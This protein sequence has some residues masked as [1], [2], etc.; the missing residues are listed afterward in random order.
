MTVHPRPISVLLLALLLGGLLGEEMVLR[1]V[2]AGSPELDELNKPKAQ[3]RVEPV[4]KKADATPAPPAPVL[5]APAGGAVVPL[6]PGRPALIIRP[7]AVV[8]VPIKSGTPAPVDPPAPVVVVRVRVLACSPAGQELHYQICVENI[9][10]L[11]AHHVLVR[12]PVPMNTR[13]LRAVPP[14]SVVDAVLTWDLGTLPGCFCREIHL[15]LQ[16]LCAGDVTN[17]ARVQFE[18]GQCVTTRIARALPAPLLV[19][20]P[21]PKIQQ[22]EPKLPEQKEPE[23]KQPEKKQP[24]QKQPVPQVKAGPAAE[25]KMDMRGPKKGF[26]KIP[27]TYTISIRNVSKVAATDVLIKNELPAGTKFIAASEP[28]KFVENQVAWVLGTLQPGEEKQVTITYESLTAGVIC[29]KAE[30]IYGK[31]SRASAEFCTEFKGIPALNTKLSDSRDPLP[32]LAGNDT[33]YVL[34]VTNPGTAPVTNLRITALV[35][36]E[37]RVTQAQGPTDPPDAPQDMKEKG[38]L[39]VFK[40][41]AALD[42]GITARYE[43]T[44]VGV[45]PGDAKV[46]MRVSADQL[47]GELLEEESTNVYESSPQPTPEPPFQPGMTRQDRAAWG[48]AL[49]WLMHTPGGSPLAPASL[50]FRQVQ[51]SLPPD[52]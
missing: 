12:N 4:P 9:A 15:V 24:E 48:Q 42:P 8:P 37:I 33:K 47:Q 17:C 7:P 32:M 5:P 19:P 13:F 3:P 21:A 6:L 30:A 50:L 2:R 46:Q 31:D 43:I 39:L 52:Q 20:A 11:P 28:G 34:E 14:P 29:N 1:H 44:A 23:K 25:L 35:S 49:W 10:P 51:R 27:V 18:H 38:Q 40:V 45:R 36:P 26:T 41:L 22:P 16:P